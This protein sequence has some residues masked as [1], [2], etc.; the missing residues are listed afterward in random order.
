MSDLYCVIGGLFVVA[1]IVVIWIIK[2][3]TRGW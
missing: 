2:T 3:K 1:V